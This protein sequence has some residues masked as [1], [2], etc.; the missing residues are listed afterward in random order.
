MIWH[1]PS[2]SLACSLRALGSWQRTVSSGCSSHSCL[3]VGLEVVSAPRLGPEILPVG[4]APGGP[5]P[6]QGCNRRRFQQQ[7]L[8]LL[9]AK[10]D[11]SAPQKW[12]ATPLQRKVLGE[13]ESYTRTS[14]RTLGQHSRKRRENGAQQGWPASGPSG[15]RE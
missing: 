6:G 8:H 12:P 3:W 9:G 14:L 11:L 5:A 1:P 4:P 13:A 7:R 15:T 10:A 2:Q